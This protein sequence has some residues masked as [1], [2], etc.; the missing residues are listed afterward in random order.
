M[1]RVGLIGAGKMG[2]SH[3]SILGAHPDVDVVG[4]ADTSSMVTDVLRRYGSFNC[5]CDY[6][7]MLHDTKP[8]AVVEA[9]PTKFHAGM[10]KELLDM[11]IHV[12]AEKPFCLTAS[13]G[14]EL[15][16]LAKKKKLVNQ[17]GYHNKFIGNF[18]EVKRLIDGGYLGNIYHFLGEAYGPV[19]TKKK[20]DTW[21]SD[22]SQG[23][24][25]LMDYASHVID[26]INYLLSPITKVH[27]AI[28]KSVYSN[29]VEDAVYALLEVSSKV[30]GVLSVNWSDETY[31]KMSTTITVIGTKGKIICDAAE[32]KVYF[33][34]ENDSGYSRGWSTKNITDL[35]RQVDFYLRG[36][37]YSAQ[38]DYFVK[39]IEG[40]VP[41]TIN[42]FESAWHTDRAIELIKN[43][44]P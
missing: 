21:R 5:F 31:R 37:E 9:V 39:T 11:G 13:Q 22:P 16:E 3:L 15:V 4:V 41:N 32:L 40:K 35:T 19:V 24:G 18:E 6:K 36:E 34:E 20:S 1:V 23:G 14:E 27:G 12:F 44:K 38:I 30:S 8:D 2:I 7:K 33:K 29:G 42:T 17:V 43:F 10:V 28:L 25:C 26:L